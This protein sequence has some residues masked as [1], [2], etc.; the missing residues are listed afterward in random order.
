[1]QLRID[2]KKYNF[3]CFVV[4]LVSR[5][6][7]SLTK[8]RYCYNCNILYSSMKPN[9]LSL[10][11]ILLGFILLSSVISASAYTYDFNSGGIYYIITGENTLSVVRSPSGYSNTVVIPKNVTYEG[12]Y[13]TVTAISEGGFWDCAKLK[14]VYLPTSITEIGDYAFR[15][16]TN[17]TNASLPSNLK[18]IGKGAFIN[19]T[20]LNSI[21]LPNAITT[22]NDAT[23]SNCVSL[24]HI[25]IPNTVTV[26]GDYAF[27][28][29]E[30][31]TN[32]TLGNSLKTIGSGAFSL[33]SGITSINLPQSLTNI[34]SWSFDQCSSLESIVFPSNGFIRHIGIGAFDNTLWY[35]NQANGPVLIGTILYKY[36]GAI[37]KNA[38]IT[39]ENGIRGIAEGAFLGCG[40]MAAI[41]LPE[42]IEHINPHAFSRCDA[43]ESVT[44]LSFTPPTLDSSECFDSVCYN[45]ATLH[46]PHVAVSDYM[47]TEYWKLFADIEGIDYAFVVDNR[48]YLMTSSN[49]VSIIYQKGNNLTYFGD[50]IIPTKVIFGGKEFTVTA[51]GDNAF[52]G[53]KNMTSITIPNTVEIIGHNAFDAC[54]GLTSIV[55]PPSVTTIGYQAF[56]G[57][58]GLTKVTIGA[59][60]K[61]IGNR[62]FF[63]CDAIATVTCEGET[64]PIM[65]SSNCFTMTCYNNATL[66]VPSDAFK[67]YLISDY[68]NR[69]GRIQEIPESFVGDV[70]GDGQV[71]IKDVA[72]MI[73]Y[74]LGSDIN[75]VFLPK[76]A[77]VDGNGEISIK[78]VTM[79]IDTLLTHS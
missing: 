7:T 53:C 56:Q 28:H 75:G 41:R 61:T 46:M 36:K 16:C 5:P 3:A 55:I 4:D 59:G 68:W 30:S 27:S 19:C 54:S 40:G 32:L 9:Y 74:L 23:F 65:E 26:I 45:Q 20:S 64:P 62:A 70:N 10:H 43:L 44:C 47:N 25:T 21:Q 2:Q 13:Y 34:G 8:F 51:I 6:D 67:D 72:I 52:V 12:T 14:S 71:T 29:C 76:Y 63:N 66:Q 77:D 57:C 38:Q 39:L 1:M 37:P 11:I 15:N 49:T 17:L 50:V 42:S 22:I 35:D 31:V 73:D 33:C 24:T 60:V 18:S 69:F 78:D 48:N 58:T 79:L